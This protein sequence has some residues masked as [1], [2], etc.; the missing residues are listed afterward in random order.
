M[1]Y[2]SFEPRFFPLENNGDVFGYYYF[3]FLSDP[4]SIN[5]PYE[6]VFKN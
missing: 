1:R 4:Q 6:N 3:T 5:N 2:A